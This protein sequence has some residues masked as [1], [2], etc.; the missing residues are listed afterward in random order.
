[1][2]HST[3]LAMA[4]E[5]DNKPLTVSGDGQDDPGQLAE[6]ENGEF[7]CWTWRVALFPFLLHLKQLH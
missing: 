1:M 3:E 4:H 6:T 2:S 5:A 7:S